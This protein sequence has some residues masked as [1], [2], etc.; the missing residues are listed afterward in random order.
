MTLRYLQTLTDIAAEQNSTIVF[1][2]PIE[3]MKCAL[4]EE[5][6]GAGGQLRDALPVRVV[7]GDVGDVGDRLAGDQAQDVVLQGAH[8]EEPLVLAVAVTPPCAHGLVVRRAANHRLLQ[9]LQPWPDGKAQLHEPV[10]PHVDVGLLFDSETQ[11]RDAVVEQGGAHTER[12]LVPQH[13]ARELPSLERLGAEAVAASQ[14]PAVG[15]PCGI[16]LPGLD[17]EVAGIALDEVPGVGGQLVRHLRHETGWTEHPQRG[18][19][20]QADAEQAIEAAEVVHVRVRD[21]HVRDP[22]DLLRRQ[23]VEVAEID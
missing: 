17:D 4:D 13:P 18:V 16:D 6:H 12:G 11:A 5:A 20:A 1:P 22:E 15:L 3:L 23:E 21:E 8:R 10:L 9:L 14:P 2:L 7:E 19:A